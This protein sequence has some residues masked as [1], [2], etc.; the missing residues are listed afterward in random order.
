M[1][2]GKSVQVKPEAWTKDEVRKR[3]GIFREQ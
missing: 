1:P 2:G 3:L